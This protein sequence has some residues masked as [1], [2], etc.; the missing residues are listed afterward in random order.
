MSI[1]THRPNLDSKIVITSIPV[2]HREEFVHV[3]L[4]KTFRGTNDHGHGVPR[5]R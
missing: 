1:G 4:F 3:L 2:S 5:Q